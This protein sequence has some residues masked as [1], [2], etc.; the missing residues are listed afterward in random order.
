MRLRNKMMTGTIC[1]GILLL[2]LGGGIPAMALTEQQAMVPG[3]YGIEHNPDKFDFTGMPMKIPSSEMERLSNGKIKVGM[4]IN[5][6][7]VDS[8]KKELLY[9]TS[10]GVYNMVKMGMEMVI[11]DYKPWPVPKVFGEATK[12]NE[13]QAVITPD[14]NLKTKDGRWWIGGTPSRLMSM[15]PR[16]R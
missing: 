4:V 10:P 2:L 9:L 7:N 15:I 11:A 14:G 16:R 6:N 8:M 13:G 1:T 12:A 5:K 3:Y